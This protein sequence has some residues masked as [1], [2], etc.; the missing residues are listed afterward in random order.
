MPGQPRNISL[1]DFDQRVTAA[2]TW[3][4]GAIVLRAGFKGLLDGGDFADTGHF[5]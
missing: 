1:A 3:T 2:V 4:L 5:V